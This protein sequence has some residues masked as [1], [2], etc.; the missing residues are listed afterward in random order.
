MM[1][2]ETRHQMTA[3]NDKDIVRRVVK[4]MLITVAQKKAPR[5]RR[6]SVFITN[7]LQQTTG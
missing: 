3:V 7:L 6:L 1:L 4:R 5:H 2:S